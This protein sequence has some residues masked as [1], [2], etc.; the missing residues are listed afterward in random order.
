MKTKEILENA[1]VNYGD[2][3]QI[4]KC[5]EEMSELTKA[6]CKYKERMTSV[7]MDISDK[8]LDDIE[9]EIADVKIMIKQLSMIFD[10]NNIKEHYK[11]K[12]ARL[13]TRLNNADNKCR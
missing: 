4:T 12:I 5:I 1:I 7:D 10:K 2:I 8:Y 9:E 3:Q 11:K 6:L 13:K